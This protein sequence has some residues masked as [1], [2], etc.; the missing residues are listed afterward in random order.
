[1]E[2]AIMTMNE[3]LT[4]NGAP[5]AATFERV[6]ALNPYVEVHFG[7]PGAHD[8]RPALALFDANGQYLD[9]C[10]A[11]MSRKMGT[12][13]STA[14]ARFFFRYYAWRL[15]TVLVGP[16]V[17]E[18]RLPTL[19]LG[20]LGLTMGDQGS[21]VSVILRYPR[22]YCLPGDPDVDHPDASIL[23]D[24]QTMRCRLRAGL[25]RVCEPL[26]D[27]LRQR[28]RVGARA[29]WIAAAE[30]CAGLLVDLLPAGSSDVLARAEVTALIGE[31]GSALRA[32]PEILSLAANGVTGLGM[33]GDDC[34]FNYKLAGEGYCDS[35]PHRS[36]EERIAAL[37]SWIAE[38]NSR[39]AVA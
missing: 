22:F 8:G 31:P 38:R 2:T 1:M 20:S 32:K 7:P 18:R 16:F 28:A 3:S 25:V 26:I 14:L 12:T 9:E 21:V 33:L 34:C 23:P 39:D 5:L 11:I 30:S 13:D 6:R 24:L 19:D 17:L 27:A 10:L 37:K 36:R 29:F 15:A 4:A 35:C